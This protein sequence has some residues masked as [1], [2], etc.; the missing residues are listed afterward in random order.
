MESVEIDDRLKTI[1]YPSLA[2]SQDEM[3]GAMVIDITKLSKSKSSAE[4][5]DLLQR[6][7][8][9]QIPYRLI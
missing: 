1:R 5:T 8:A 2:E 6:L 3:D 7:N 9:D 4:I